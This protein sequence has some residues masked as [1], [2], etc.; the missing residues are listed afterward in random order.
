MKK[1]WILAAV[2]LAVSVFLS[3]E[4]VGSLRAYW[5]MHDDYREAEPLVQLVW[6]LSHQLEDFVD[7]HDRLPSDLDEIDRFSED[8]D[9][10]PL[11]AYDHLFSPNSENVFSLSVNRSHSFTINEKFEPTLV[12]R[13]SAEQAQALNP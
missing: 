11:K 7:Q 8:F 10:S 9:F 4:I 1:K 13:R 6:P 2:G 5:K 3:Y 12:W